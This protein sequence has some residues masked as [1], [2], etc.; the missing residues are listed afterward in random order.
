MIST[1][2]GAEEGTKKRENAVSKDAQRW[3]A[4]FDIGTKYRDLNEVFILQ[5]IEEFK[6]LTGIK[7]A[8]LVDLGCGTGDT[9]ARFCKQDIGVTGIDFSAVALKKANLALSSCDSDVFLIEADLENLD[10]V[11]IKTTVGTLWLCKFVLAFI[12]DKA[13]FLKNVRDKMNKGDA[14]L[15]MTPVLHDVINYQKEDKPSIAIRVEEADA[16][17]L[18]IFGNRHIFSNEYQGERGHTVSYL[19]KK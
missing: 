6:S 7:L 1:T 10:K 18:K 3:D 13:K 17:L 15:L 5:L 8:H 12:K 11:K 2:T 16:L 14:F 19:V 4:I 9:L